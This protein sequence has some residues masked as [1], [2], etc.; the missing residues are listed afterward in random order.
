[1]QVVK[2]SSGLHV[3]LISVDG[4]HASDLTM[5]VAAHRDST[6]A[7]LTARGT[8][9]QHALTSFPSDSFPGLLAITTGG[10][11]RSTGVYYHDSYDRSLY[12]PRSNCT[13]APGTEVAY[14]E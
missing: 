6:L 9:Y 8:T 12:P 5:Y 3:L 2:S 14:Y 13:G 4:M 1:G 7:R 11:P 10:T